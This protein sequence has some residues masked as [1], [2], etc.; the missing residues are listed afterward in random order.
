[1]NLKASDLYKENGIYLLIKDEINMHF[2]TITN[3]IIKENQS[4]NNR[5][6][7]ILPLKYPCMN[8][9]PYKCAVFIYGK[10]YDELVSNGYNVDMSKDSNKLTLIISWNDIIS[11]KEII[12][13]E[14]KIN[15]KTKKNI[16]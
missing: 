6:I 8:Y 14:K 10:I 4:G 16:N 1:M 3:Q 13:Y 12:T 2:R 15:E 11:E 5:T 7:Y 9:D